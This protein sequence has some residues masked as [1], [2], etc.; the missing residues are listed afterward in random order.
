MTKRKMTR[1]GAIRQF[2]IEC[3]GGG[4]SGYPGNRHAAL[5]L[6]RECVA[7]ACPLWSYRPGTRIAK[8]GRDE[9]CAVPSGAVA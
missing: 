5:K 7:S 8:R 9:H 3:M 6:A 2:C 4:R 1:N